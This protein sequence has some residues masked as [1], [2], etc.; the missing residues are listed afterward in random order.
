M[1]DFCELD[2]STLGGFQ[3]N[4][5]FLGCLAL[6]LLTSY[7]FDEFTDGTL[8]I[9]NELNGRAGSWAKGAIISEREYGQF[10][11]V[12]DEPLSSNVLK[13]TLDLKLF[14]FGVAILSF[15]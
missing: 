9:N 13:E 2:G 14:V 5:C 11:C 7:G 1:D 6:S 8:F 4:G 10:D 15:M 12:Y 3:K